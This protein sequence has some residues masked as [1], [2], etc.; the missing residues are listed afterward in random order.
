M[1]PMTKNVAVIRGDGIGPEVIEATLGALDA[2]GFSWDG[3]LD[4]DIVTCEMEV[5]DSVFRHGEHEFSRVIFM[6]DAVDNNVV[7]VE[8]Q[9]AIRLFKHSFHELDFGQR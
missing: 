8:Q 1:V 7:D 6:I 9:I 5:F 2:V 4:V 3:P